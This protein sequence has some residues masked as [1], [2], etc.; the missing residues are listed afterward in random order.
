MP[1]YEY[2]DAIITSAKV[3]WYCKHH[4]PFAV[5]A[6]DAVFIRKLDA[7][8]E[9][10]IFGGGFLLSERAAAE[11]AAAERAAATRWKLSPRELEMQRLISSA[12]KQH[13]EGVCK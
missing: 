2:P 1:K 4:T 11:R 7:Q 13:T 6:E 10:G 5:S 3:G 12:T 9:N 8:G